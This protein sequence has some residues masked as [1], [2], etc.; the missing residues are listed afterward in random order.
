MFMLFLSCV[1][2]AGMKRVP[3]WDEHDFKRAREEAKKKESNENSS[4]GRHTESNPRDKRPPKQI[5]AKALSEM[6]L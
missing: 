5:Q 1:S 6:S 2:L 4:R 3:A